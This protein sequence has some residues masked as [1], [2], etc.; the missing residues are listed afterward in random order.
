MSSELA[1][2]NRRF[3]VRNHTRTP[4]IEPDAYRLE[5]FGDGLSG[6]P[7]VNDPLTLSLDDI[8]SLPRYTLSAFLECTGNGRALFAIQQQMEVP[9]TPWLLGGIGMATWSGVRL[10]TVLRWARYG[11]RRST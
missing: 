3:F 11:Q 5:L 4:H 10:S 7:T 1:T 2:A 6:S 8:R 9:G